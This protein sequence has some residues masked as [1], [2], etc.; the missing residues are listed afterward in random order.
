MFKPNAWAERWPIG[1]HFGISTTRSVDTRL[2][3]SIK[4]IYLP[5][6]YV[7]S[8]S[9]QHFLEPCAR[10]DRCK[11]PPSIRPIFNNTF[12]I[13]TFDMRLAAP[14]PI[15]SRLRLLLRVRIALRAC[16]ECLRLKCVKMPHSKSHK[17]ARMEHVCLHARCAWCHATAPPKS[18]SVNKE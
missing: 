7:P 12:K 13:R 14:I 6:H 4:C 9:V 18:Q 11:L 3:C 8:R 15:A 5:E 1:L 17:E 10:G 2:P 16:L